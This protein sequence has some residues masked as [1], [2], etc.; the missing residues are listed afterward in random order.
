MVG[1][2]PAE[3]FAMLKSKCQIKQA[4]EMINQ[5]YEI[6]FCSVDGPGSGSAVGAAGK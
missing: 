5:Y 3:E 4:F 1:M 6:A 2:V